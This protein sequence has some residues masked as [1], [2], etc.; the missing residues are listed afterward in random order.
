MFPGLSPSGSGDVVICYTVFMPEDRRAEG[1][2]ELQERLHLRQRRAINN[3]YSTLQGRQTAETFAAYTFEEAADAQIERIEGAGSQLHP[4]LIDGVER[5]R[6]E[7]T[8]A[9]EELKEVP[10]EQFLDVNAPEVTNTEPDAEN[11]FWV[12]WWG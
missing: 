8:R 7:L 2:L 5:I 9:V 1:E 4:G 11:E 3:A 12:G 6:G 10:P